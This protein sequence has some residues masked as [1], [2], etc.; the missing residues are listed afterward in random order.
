V[1]AARASLLGSL[2]IR[3]PELYENVV[4]V[5]RVEVTVPSELRTSSSVGITGVKSI[6]DDTENRLL[7]GGPVIKA[8]IASSSVSP[9]D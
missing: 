9:E 6:T 7:E 1:F 4:M 5:S 3:T 2:K 8:S